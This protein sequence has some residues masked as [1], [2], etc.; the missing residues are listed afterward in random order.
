M[1]AQNLLQQNQN[2][3]NIN[4]TIPWELALFNNGENGE[5]P[6]ELIMELYE[7]SLNAEIVKMYIMI[8]LIIITLA[9]MLP[10]FYIIKM[11]PRKILL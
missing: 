8:G 1:I 7:V 4:D 2:L 3:G 5:M 11:N 6:V 10:I 9:T